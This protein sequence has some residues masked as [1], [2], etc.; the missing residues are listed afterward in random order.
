[1]L[2]SLNQRSGR[3]S[4]RRNGPPDSTHRLS[5][6]GSLLWNGKTPPA[7]NPADLVVSLLVYST[8]QRLGAGSGHI[9]AHPRP[10]PTPPLPQLHQTPSQP[11]VLVSQDAPH[12]HPSSPPDTNSFTAAVLYQTALRSHFVVLH[13]A[14]STTSLNRTVCLADFILCLCRKLI[15]ILFYICIVSSFLCLSVCKRL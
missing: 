3:K 11:P 15:Y 2:P 8:A 14:A 4:R 6:Y 7:A 9:T 12:L 10:Q 5:T 1:M 13:S